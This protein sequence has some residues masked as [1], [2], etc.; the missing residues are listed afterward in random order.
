MYIKG[1]P[2]QAELASIDVPE[3]PRRDWFLTLSRDMTG[4]VM[5][6]IGTTTMHVN[7]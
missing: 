6:E 5:H 3:A 1:P 7:S 4:E 2:V